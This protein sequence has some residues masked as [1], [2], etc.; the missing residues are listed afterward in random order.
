MTMSNKNALIDLARTFERRRCDHHTLDEPLSTIACFTSVID[1]KGSRTNKNRYIVASQEEEVRR[2]ARGIKGVPSVYVKR[3]VMVMEPMSEG[4][5]GM[6]EGAERGK[7]RGGIRKVGEQGEK[8]RKRVEESEEQVQDEKEAKKRRTRGL[9]G[10]NPL[11]VKKAR[12]EVVLDKAGPIQGTGTSDRE[13]AHDITT[14]NLMAAGLGISTSYRK[15]R[16]RKHKS[17]TLAHGDNA[18]AHVD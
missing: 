15:K 3:S 18:A 2:W 9:K 14:E 1:P 12:K 7:L 8:K 13:A 16:R 6:R 17:G 11:S 10:P 5:L 4:S